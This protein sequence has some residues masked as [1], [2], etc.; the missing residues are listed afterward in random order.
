MAKEQTLYR[1][2]DSAYHISY[3]YAVYANKNSASIGEVDRFDAAK[4]HLEY[5]GKDGLLMQQFNSRKRTMDRGFGGSD[6]F[7]GILDFLEN[8][9]QALGNAD[10]EIA[11]AKSGIYE[12]ELQSK[13]NHISMPQFKEPGTGADPAIIAQ[14]IVNDVNIFMTKL[15][16]AMNNI[17]NMVKVNIEAYKKLIIDQF[18]ESQG[19]SYAN[20]GEFAAKVIEIFLQHQGIKKLNLGSAE[21]EDTNLRT[22]ANE[23]ILL[24]EALPEYGTSSSAGALNK[25]HKYSTGSMRKGETKETKGVNLLNKLMDKLRGLYSN[26]I[27]KAGEAAWAE[28]EI[29]AGKLVQDDLAKIVSN[30]KKVYTGKDITI[31][32]TTVGADSVKSEKTSTGI[33]VSKPDVK[34]SINFNGVLV[35]YGVSVKEYKANPNNKVPSVDIVS[36]T[37]FWAALNKYVGNRPASIKYVFNVAGGRSGNAHYAN[38]NLTGPSEGELVSQWENIKKTV[39]IANFLDFLAGEVNAANTLSVLYLVVNGTV[40]P[41][42]NIL[43]RVGIED[44]GVTLSEG[45]L[46]NL[47]RRN[48][49]ERHNVWKQSDAGR[50]TPDPGLAE[51]RSSNVQ[52]GI[53][54]TLYAAKMKVS[55]SNLTKFV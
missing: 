30:N 14:E 38:Y 41:V 34:V 7:G 2:T 16:E 15:K 28:V 17:T 51:T 54:N 23:C 22:V 40:M 1:Q 37:S 48:M 44:I 3:K 33:S 20:K 43:S 25:T 21:I 29:Q 27:G 8:P 49:A 4:A 11:N 55:L 26:V 24:I 19:V 10:K 46:S 13:A 31:T 45:S 35:E 42:S 39:T 47:T 5:L 50:W 52:S 9:D 36:N 6:D 12:T 32:A 53:I 18:C